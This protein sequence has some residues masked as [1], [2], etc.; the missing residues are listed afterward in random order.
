MIKRILN[1][2][3]IKSGFI[4]SISNFL[5]SV[6]SYLINLLMARNFSL[7]DYGEYMTAISYVLMFAAPF[8]AFNMIIIKRIGLANNEKK[9]SLALSIEKW[10]FLEIINLKKEIILFFLVILVV[11]NF[12][13]NMSLSAIIFIF[14]FFFINM[15]QNFYT[16]VL[17]SYKKFLTAGIFLLIFFLLRFS[18]ILGVIFSIPSLTNIFLAIILSG[19]ISIFWAKKQIRVK[20]IKK[21]TTVNFKSFTYYLTKPSVIIPLVSTLGLVGLINIDLILIKTF[22]SN[23]L[24]GLYA[25]LSL[26]GKIVVYLCIPLSTVAYTFFAAK[27]SK[28]QSMKILFFLIGAIIFIGIIGTIGYSL[29]PSLII[30]IF[31]GDKFINIKDLVWLTPI[32]GTLYSLIY[33]FS[34]YFVSQ[35][36]KFAFL[37]VAAAFLQ[38]LGLYFFHNNLKQVIMVNILVMLSLALIY[39]LGIIRRQLNYVPKKTIS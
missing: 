8:T 26:L 4:F 7:S 17:Q 19:L 20:K 31:F 28:N 9:I 36:S 34:Q 12:L 29:F 14:L 33:L 16:S 22:F 21:I 38:T 35:N 32:W 25:S 37:T 24:S 30:N 11:M 2:S 5:V 10:I 6:L 3:F 23:E 27:D 39:L 1:N 15:F 13:G 18:F